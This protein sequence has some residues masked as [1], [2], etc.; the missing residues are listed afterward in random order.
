M[1]QAEY[2]CVTQKH[3]L[4]ITS[5]IKPSLLHFTQAQCAFTEHSGVGHSALRSHDTMGPYY[6][7]MSTFHFA[8]F[9]RAQLRH[10]F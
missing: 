5:S 8:V 3:K 6:C 4:P 7:H 9:A 1:D 10:S 2:L